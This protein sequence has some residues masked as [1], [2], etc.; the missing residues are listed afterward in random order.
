MD[1]TN[2][3]SS[4]FSQI[5]WVKVLKWASI[6]INLIVFLKWTGSKVILNEFLLG[7][8]EG[9]IVSSQDIK[10]SCTL[11]ITSR[12]ER[13]N[14]AFFY[15]EQ[16]HAQS[17]LIRGVD[18]LDDYE[19]DLLFIFRKRWNPVF[20]R[21]FHVAYNQKM[22]GEQIDDRETV[23]YN[24]NCTVHNILFKPKLKVTIAG[25]GVNFQ[26]VLHKS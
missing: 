24:W 10:L 20:Y 15:Y 12:P 17:I 4:F 23:K 13:A 26:G 7:R 1:S 21:E 3:F 2:H 11:I 6:T 22:Q 16:I 8:W 19:D 9:N 25:N 18:E 14:K 5:D